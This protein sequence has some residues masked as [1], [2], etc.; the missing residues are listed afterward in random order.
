MRDKED[1]GEIEHKW[2]QRWRDA[3]LFEP[4]IDEERKK[5]FLTVAWIYPSGPMHVGH[6][7]TYTIPDII[8]RHKRMR[9][10][11]VLFP[12]GF[13]LTGSPIVGATERIASGDQRYITLLK[14]VYHVPPSV[15]DTLAEPVKFADHFKA[16]IK[17][18]MIDMGY[19]IDWTREYTSIYPRFKRMVEWQYRRLREMGFVRKGSHPV[20]YC[21]NDR[22]PVTDHD[23]LDGEGVR[24]V[25]YTLVKYELDG[26]IYLPAATLRPETIY[27]VTN[28]WVNPEAEYVEAEVDGERW[29]VSRAALE[30]L[31]HQMDVGTEK[32]IGK[33]EALVGQ[34]VRNPVTGETVEILPAPFVDPVVGTGVVASVPGHAPYDY[35]AL[36]EAGMPLKP[37]TIIKVGEE[38]VGEES[39]TEREIRGRG[40]SSQ[41]DRA[42]LDEATAVVYKKEYAKGVMCVPPFDGVPVKV[43]KERIKGL[44]LAEGKASIMYDFSERPVTCRCGTP[45]VVKIVRDQWFLRYSD[46]RWKKEVRDYLG[47]VEFVPPE[48]EHYFANVLDWLGDWPCARLVGMGTRIPWDPKWLIESL[49]DSTIYMAFYTIADR[50]KQMERE[51][52]DRDFDYIF[53]GKGDK[54]QDPGKEKEEKEEL[55]AMRAEFLYWY[56]LDVRASANDLIPN[57]LTFFLY[58]HLALFPPSMW[59]KGILSFGMGLLEGGKMSASRGNVVLLRDAIAEYGADAVRFCLAYLAEPWQDFDWRRGQIVSARRQIQRWLELA[60]EVAEA[61]KGGKE[62]GEKEKGKT[63]K[64]KEDL[65]EWLESRFQ[66]HAKATD[67]CLESYQTRKGLQ[68]G[69]YAIMQDVQWYIRRGGELYGLRDLFKDWA[70]LMSPFIP[71]VS[72]EVWHLLDGEGFVSTAPYPCGKGKMNKELEERETYLGAVLEDVG[73]LSRLMETKKVYLYAD[74]PQE[75]EWLQG[76]RDFLTRERRTPVTVYHKDEA[77]YDPKGRAKRAKKGRP[78]IYI[79]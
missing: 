62:K 66:H 15:I 33:G 73:H 26:K 13:H 45:C 31:G 61:S 35:I 57:H 9:G 48:S 46:D 56:P 21:P 16:G 1:L 69:F 19:A 4:S 68:H 6:G 54:G 2:Q 23:L 11:N 14:D 52:S 63:E 75:V 24:I 67:E 77:V 41:A 10:Y 5:F 34:R 25:E 22:N 74:N 58:H 7:R 37:R 42:L 49:S 40:I 29:I 70:R 76:A 65:V 51:P 38:S 71:H 18:C 3:H 78:A 28:L 59:P 43:A 60:R 8:A 17:R 72:E 20:K 79:E 44:M 64:E 50:M 53:L 36:K 27:G 12:M 55:E 30:G 47:E 32:E 39:A